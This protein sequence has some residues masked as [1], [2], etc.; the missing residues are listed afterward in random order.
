[1]YLIRN[2]KLNSS[3]HLKW[4]PDF[5]WC[6]SGRSFI[7]AVPCSEW[8]WWRA[9]LWVS[10]SILPRPDG[11][12]QTAGCICWT[13]PTARSTSPPSTSLYE[14]A[15]WNPLA[16][17]TLRLVQC[18]AL[19][20]CS[21]S[22]KCARI[23]WMSNVCMILFPHILQ[24]RMVFEQLKQLESKGVKLQIAVNAPQTS[25]Q[26]TAELAATGRYI[27]TGQYGAHFVT[28][29]LG[30]LWIKAVQGNII[31]RSKH[32][33]THLSALVTNQGCRLKTASKN[34]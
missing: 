28:S 21:I 19:V 29:L 6:V 13:R 5:L 23:F 1:M 10:T 3:S 15:I 11:A 9:S 32:T 8:I 18:H 14:A 24:G 16:P 4:W 25:T 34:H 27:M 31:C 30:P 2:Q 22:S 7:F 20:S 33:R 12:S 17:L 26:D